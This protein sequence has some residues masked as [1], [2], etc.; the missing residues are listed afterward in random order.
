MLISSPPFSAPYHP[1]GAWA[2]SNHSTIGDE[3]HPGTPTSAAI[4]SYIEQLRL[5]PFPQP[6][7][8]N[9]RH[10]SNSQTLMGTGQVS[11]AVVHWDRWSEVVKGFDIHDCMWVRGR[12]GGA[13]PEI[14]CFNP[15]LDMTPLPAVLKLF[16][17]MPRFFLL[18]LATHPFF[19]Q[20]FLKVRRLQARYDDI[21][22]FLKLSVTTGFCLCSSWTVTRR[23]YSGSPKSGVGCIHALSW[24]SN[25]HTYVHTSAYLSGDSQS[26]G[27]EGESQDFAAGLHTCAPLVCTAQHKQMSQTWFHTGYDFN[28]RNVKVSITTRDRAIWQ[29]SE[30]WIWSLFKKKE[31]T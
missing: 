26:C 8:V 9:T 23:N 13:V 27:R 10:D 25:T 28:Y 4:F 22:V 11:C 24:C 1:A 17:W 14:A 21:I 19:Q 31:R 2:R 6:S 16:Q 20:H 18:L 12:R 29:H 30:G 15:S 5:P 3:R 7:S